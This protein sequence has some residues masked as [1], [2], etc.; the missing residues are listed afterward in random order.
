VRTIPVINKNDK[1]KIEEVIESKDILP[2]SEKLN[3]FYFAIGTVVAI[4][5]ILGAI[6]LKYIDVAEPK[7]VKKN[8]LIEVFP[9]V[10]PTEVPKKIE[11]T[12]EVQN[13]S[14]KAG[15]GAKSKLV[16]EKLGYQVVSL[17]NAE[18]KHVGTEL[19]L[20]TEIV[21]Q[22]EEIIDRLKNDYPNIVFTG[23]LKESTATARLILG[24]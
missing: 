17:G 18:G 19:Y 10:S 23:E 5:I 2:V 14:G 20:K 6:G 9:T 13:G 16:L 24:K 11:V 12:F 8:E 22:K 21:D 7:V 3:R 15:V 1:L 4:V